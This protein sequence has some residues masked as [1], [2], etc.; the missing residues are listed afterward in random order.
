MAS[1]RRAVLDAEDGDACGRSG[2]RPVALRALAPLAAM[3]LGVVAIVRDL[4]WQRGFGGVG[5]CKTL[6]RKV[7][8]LKVSAIVRRVGNAPCP[9]SPSGFK[10]Q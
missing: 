4:A 6:G 1:A 5:G 3:R 9:G 7:Q 2:R 10:Y 8:F